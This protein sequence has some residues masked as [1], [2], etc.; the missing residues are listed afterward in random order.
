M[1]SCSGITFSSASFNPPIY[2]VYCSLKA[3]IRWW[4]VSGTLDILRMIPIFA[5]SGSRW[6]NPSVSFQWIALLL[7]KVPLH[8][9]SPD[10]VKKP[11]QIKWKSYLAMNT[12]TLITILNVMP[13][14]AK[15]TVN[16]NGSIGAQKAAESKAL[17]YISIF[18]C[19]WNSFLYFCAVEIHFYISTW[20]CVLFCMNAFSL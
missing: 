4:L 18:L 15:M 19:G 5:L 3:K 12:R 9:A 16:L 7:R 8:P 6:Y 10:Q 14:L 13:T 11:I 20:L 1:D 2:W 17:K